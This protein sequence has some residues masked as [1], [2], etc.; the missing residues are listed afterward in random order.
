MQF[1]R[2]L[3]PGILIQRYKR[4][5]ADVEIAG[6]VTVTSS[7]PNTGSMIGLTRPGS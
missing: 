1:E 5:L 6:G 3:I 4:F 7:C 2:P